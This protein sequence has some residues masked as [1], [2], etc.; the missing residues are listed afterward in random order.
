MSGEAWCL[1]GKIFRN[2]PHLS[3]CLPSQWGLQGFRPSFQLTKPYQMAGYCLCMGLEAQDQ[4]VCMDCTATSLSNTSPRAS[5]T[6]LVKPLEQMSTLSCELP[7]PGLPMARHAQLQ[8][9]CPAWM[10][11]GG[12]S[13]LLLW[14]LAILS[15]FFSCTWNRKELKEAKLQDD[16]ILSVRADCARVGWYAGRRTRVVRLL[17]LGQWESNIHRET[18]YLLYCR[19]WK[20]PS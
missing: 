15:Y 4:C 10:P 14:E 2:V 11:S 9:L 8:P 20:R 13:R 6:A 18:T 16:A 19:S 5:L 3:C 17:A 12:R 7:Q 1:P